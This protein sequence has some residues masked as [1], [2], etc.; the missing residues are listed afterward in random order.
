LRQLLKRFVDDQ[1]SLQDVGFDHI[2]SARMLLG[3]GRS[4][5]VVQIPGGVVVARSFDQLIVRK[6]TEPAAEFDY[7][8]HIPGQI[9]IPELGRSFGARIVT[10]IESNGGFERV[11]VDGSRLG[12]YVRIRRWKPGDYYRPVGLPAGKLKRLFQRA[13]IS[14]NERHRWPVFVSDA[15]I[16]WVASFP[17]SREFASRG[18]S[19]RI[20]A[21]EALPA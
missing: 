15:S 17:V 10:E 3:P 8:L 12:P 11:F 19:Q 18:C 6:R 13:R 1:P 7:E 20:V 9:H 2:E 5:K 14:R 16:V 4:G 21:L